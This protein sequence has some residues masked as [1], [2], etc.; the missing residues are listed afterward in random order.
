MHFPLV[1]KYNLTPFFSVHKYI[2][3]TFQ[4]IW[5]KKK[6]NCTYSEMCVHAGP[7]GGA[8]EILVLPVWNVLVS[9]RI[10]K[11]FGQTKIYHIT[12][13]ALVQRKLFI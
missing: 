8:S 6:I 13:V 5:A 2:L 7:A 3:T 4:C 1:V 10:S 9:A 12:Q 11:L